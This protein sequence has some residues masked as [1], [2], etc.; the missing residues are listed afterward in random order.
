V[1]VPLI[2]LLRAGLISPEDIIIDA[3][4][5][6]TG[7]GRSAKQVAQHPASPQARYSPY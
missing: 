1:Q 4:S 5:G 3:K 2:P 7:A 6:T